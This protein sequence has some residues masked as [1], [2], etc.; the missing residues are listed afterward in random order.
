VQRK[1]SLHDQRIVATAI[2]IHDVLALR[3]YWVVERYQNL[4]T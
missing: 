1:E 3:I 4:M 2:A